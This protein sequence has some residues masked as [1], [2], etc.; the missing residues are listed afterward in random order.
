MYDKHEAGTKLVAVSIILGKATALF[1]QLRSPT[2]AYRGFLERNTRPTRCLVW[3]RR[4]S[5]C[6]C[7]TANSHIQSRMAHRFFRA[8][9]PIYMSNSSSSF[10][11]DVGPPPPSF[12]PRPTR[13]LRPDKERSPDLAGAFPER[14]CL[15]VWFRPLI[16][17]IAPLPRRASPLFGGADEK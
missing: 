16:D 8:S 13:S 14:D 9:S 10:S 17:E 15:S 4:S 1:P 6:T 3:N 2:S 12:L 11:D 5:K 7:I